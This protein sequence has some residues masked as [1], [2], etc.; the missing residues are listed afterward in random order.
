MIFILIFEGLSIPASRAKGGNLDIYVGK[1]S[2]FV[3]TVDKVAIT[4][5]TDV[6]MKLLLYC[7][8]YPS[9]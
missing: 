3:L 4:A 8:I 5:S 9:F 6:F 2:L 7:L 1:F